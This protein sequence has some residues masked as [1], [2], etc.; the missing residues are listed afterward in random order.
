MANLKAKVRS[1]I[2]SSIEWLAV[3]D[4]M[5]KWRRIL[6]KNT[7]TAL[8]LQQRKECT[9]FYRPYIK[10]KSLGH[11]FYT[12]KT[13]VFDVRYIPDDLYYGKIDRYFCDYKMAGI[14]DNKC[15]YNAMF[16]GRVKQPDIFAY[17]MGG[18]W[19]DAEMN[20]I[21]MEELCS[22]VDDAEALV[23]KKALDSYGGK[24]VS[25]IERKDGEMKV[26]FNEAVKPITGDIV[27]QYPVRQHRV[28][29]ALH[30]ESVNTIR[31]L[32]LFRNGKVKI[33]STIVRIGVGGAK[34]DNASSGGITC[35]VLPDGRLKD[36]AYS[37]NGTKFSKHPTTGVAFDDIVVPAYDEICR[38]V[39]QLHPLFPYFRNISWDF[40]V[41]EEGQ[42]ILIE[43][44]LRSGELDFHQL[45]NG[46]LFGD[47]TEEILNEVFE[48]K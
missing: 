47:D 7:T 3:F 23:I 21:S 4:S 15:F 39:H 9:S 8:N 33:Y 41:N 45:N 46:P 26:A 17:R 31:L 48:R 12:E 34:V 6:Q 25:F 28:M 1:M 13:G 30:A 24:G 36:C 19:Y 38:L 32:S 44:N 11:A 16:D 18:Y 5:R 14:L 27:I 10:I 22:A 43:V 40:C 2:D 29:S 35:G 42:P 37:A 20:L